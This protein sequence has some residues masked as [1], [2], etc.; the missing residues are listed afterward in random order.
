MRVLTRIRT[1]AVGGTHA[2]T[3]GLIAT[4]T[5][6]RLDFL[7]AF[8]DERNTKRRADGRLV[9]EPKAYIS[10]IRKGDDEKTR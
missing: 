8:T 3:G 5:P 4:E 10:I 9:G 7:T 1:T 6:S 2:D